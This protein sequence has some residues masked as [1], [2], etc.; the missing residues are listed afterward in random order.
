MLLDAVPR[1]PPAED[2]PMFF[3][4]PMAGAAALIAI[5][6]PLTTGLDKLFGQ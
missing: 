2:Y 5:H 3:F 1:R 4:A 6:Q